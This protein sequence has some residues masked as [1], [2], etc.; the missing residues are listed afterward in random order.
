M[1]FRVRIITSVLGF[2]L[3]LFVV[4]FASVVGSGTT[5]LTAD[6]D[7]GV[8]DEPAGGYQWG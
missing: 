3:G 6:G 1:S 5:Y 8:G 4:I 7:N 2:I